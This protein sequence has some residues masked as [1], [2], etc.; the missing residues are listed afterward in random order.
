MA[1]IEF[2]HVTK[3]FPD[4]TV[5][6]DE[7]ELTVQ[8]GDFM[9]FVGP[10]GCG[11]TTALRMVAGLESVTEGEIRI[12]GKVVNDLEPAT[13]AGCDGQGDHPPPAGVPDGRAPLEPRRA[14]PRSDARRARE[15]P[16]T[17]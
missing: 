6:V 10:S 2:D 16:P 5:A 15:A 4:G 1:A 12:G 3:R 13:A 17:P 8:D 14:T 7:I 9:I 11:K